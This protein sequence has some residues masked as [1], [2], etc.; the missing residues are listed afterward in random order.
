[1][2]ASVLA[3]ALA[4]GAMVV[5]AVPVLADHVPGQETPALGAP[6]KEA[7]ATRTI[8]LDDGSRY[9]TVT[10]GDT[11]TFVNGAKRFTWVADTFNSPIQLSTIAPRDFG[12]GHVTL[13][14][15]PHP[16]DLATGS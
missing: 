9:V 13:Y 4:A 3:R 10:R 14:V 5:V 1:M 7:G 12:T 11:V 15:A 6:G 2:K 16:R 8:R